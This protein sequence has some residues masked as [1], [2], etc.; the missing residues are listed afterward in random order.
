LPVPELGGHTDEALRESGLAD[1]EI[2][3]LRAAKVIV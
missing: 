1:A 2:A 3:K